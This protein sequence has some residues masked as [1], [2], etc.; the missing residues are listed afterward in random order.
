MKLKK[1]SAGP[2]PGA[3]RGL[4]PD[5]RRNFFGGISHRSTK[6]D[7]FP[8]MDI[9]LAKTTV[10]EEILPHPNSLWTAIGG[11]EFDAPPFFGKHRADVVVVGGGF[12][13][14][15]AAL[16]L[17][18]SGARAVVL[19]AMRIGWG[20]SG[21]SG[22]QINPLPPVW[23]VEEIE[24]FVPPPF[25]GRYIKAALNSADEIFSLVG[26]LN[27][28]CG[29]RRCGWLRVAHCRPAG[30]IMRKQCDSW[31]RMGA[32]IRLLEGDEL[33]AIVGSNRFSSGM[34][35]PAGGCLRPLD[36]VRG[37]ACAARTAGAT[38]F[39]G[40]PAIEVSPRTGG[41]TIKTPRGEISAKKVLI[42]TNA[43]TGG[44]H[45]GLT[46]LVLP[47]VSIQAATAPLDA[48]L[49]REILPGG[50]TLSDTR[51]VIFY[52][53][54]E[55]DNRFLFGSLG[56]ID[57]E[58]HPVKFARLRMEAE[59]IFP[60]LRGARWEHQW[61]GRVAVTR[62]HM[63]ILCELAP[64]LM[65]GMGYNGRGVA[66]SAVMGR[67]LA[68][69]ALGQPAMECVFPPGPFRG[70]PPRFIAIPAASLAMEWMRFRDE[71]EV[72]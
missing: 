25:A 43:H 36:Y 35:M 40:S 5:Q 57:G 71:A 63:P 64:G 29:A 27:I 21:R 9:S 59:K 20:A 46:R 7:K 48:N 47:L 61:G 26:R 44:L 53:R 12:T 54:L 69:R 11:S 18:E 30:E 70:W 28:A 65:A 68:E 8:D 10:S 51:R 15:R 41:W 19:E 32:D 55:P 22:G 24:N 37:L 3:G 45:S 66:M 2:E 17:A 42:C 16:G 6:H 1:S 72:R 34:L 13:G 38:I 62:N 60:R 4:P 31:R 52:G 50:T 14:L 39:A 58:G 67:A 56:R 49:A 23:G 33:N